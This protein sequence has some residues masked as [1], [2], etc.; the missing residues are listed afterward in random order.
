MNLF[1]HLKEYGMGNGIIRRQSPI[2]E[3]PGY[4]GD[5]SSDH[6]YGGHTFG[7]NDISDPSK[8]WY[9]HSFLSYSDYSGCMVERANVEYFKDEFNIEG[10]KLLTGGFF[11]RAIA[12]RLDVESNELLDILDALEDY[13]VIDDSLLSEMEFNAIEESWV[14]YGR[15]DLKRE[16]LKQYGKELTDEEAD[17]MRLHVE[18]SYTPAEIE[19]GGSVYWNI[20]D[21]ISKNNN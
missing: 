9:F 16:Y 21:I 5:F 6:Y 14:E 10:V 1:E 8:F 12:I 20:D 13:P 7:I 3:E 4:Y 18:Q 2:D 15:D 11:T 19:T 17:D